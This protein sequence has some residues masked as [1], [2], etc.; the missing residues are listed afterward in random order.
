MRESPAELSIAALDPNF[1]A[2]DT[3][4]G[5]R[6]YDARRLRMEGQGWSAHELA[7]AYDR[8]PARAQQ[9]VR[10]PVWQLSRHSAGLAVR[11]VTDASSISVRWTLRGASAGMQHMPVTGQ[12]GLDLYARTDEA[13]RFVGVTRPIRDGDNEALLVSELSGALREYVLHLPLYN[14][15]E[16]VAVGVP[17]AARI[18]PASPRAKKAV[19]CYGTSIVHGGCASRPGMAYPAILSRRLGRETLNLGFS[20]N[21]QAEPEVAALLAE[22]DPALFVVDPLPNLQP[23]QVTERLEPFV[24]ALRNARPRTPILLVE[25]IAYT[26]G[27]VHER[28]RSRYTSSNANLRAAWQRLRDAGDANVHLAA[29]DALLGEDGEATVDGTHPTD[30]G[31]MRMAETLTPV[32]EPLLM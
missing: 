19:V 11:F 20:G 28:R 27:C 18:A 26:D 3:E 23:A 24:Q 7:G 6:W 16:R 13:W 22:L 15:V 10:E 29:G 17:E 14:G 25:S 12:S 8:L 1:A 31:F 9:H 32:I 30:L 4:Q 2:A 21:G 5:L